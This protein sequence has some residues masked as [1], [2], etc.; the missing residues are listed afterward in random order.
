MASSD[1]M[2][3]ECKHRNIPQAFLVDISR[4]SAM[5][6]PPEMLAFTQQKMKSFFPLTQR[7]KSEQFDYTLSLKIVD[8]FPYNSLYSSFLPCCIICVTK[9]LAVHTPPII[10]YITVCALE[11]YACYG[12]YVRVIS[13]LQYIFSLF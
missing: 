11:H 10:Q 4:G 5:L 2:K 13:M 9:K 3:R 6:L 12:Y 7:E 1:R 8:L